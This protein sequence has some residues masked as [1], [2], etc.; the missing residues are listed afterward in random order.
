MYTVKIILKSVSKV[1]NLGNLVIEVTFKSEGKRERVY[2][3]TNEKVFSHHFLKSKI[4]KSNP[5][6][7]Q[8]W[9]RVEEVHGEVKKVL[10]EIEEQYGFC[11]SGLFKDRFF[12]KDEFQEKDF[13]CLYGEFIE[14][15]RITLKPKLV[16]KLKAIENHLNDFFGTRKI[17]PQD[18]N[19]EIINKLVQY[20][21]D[22]VGL[23]PNTIAKNFKFLRQFLNHLYNE[24]I[25]KSS[26][27][28]R[29]QYPREVETHSVV[30]S[31]EEVRKI[32]EYIPESGKFSKVKDLFL[33]LIFTGL[34]FSDAVRINQSWKKGEF[35]VVNTQKTGERVEIPIHGLLRE[36]LEK[37]EYDFSPIVIS[38]QKFNDYVKMLCE[39]AE[40][41]EMVEVVRYMK[42]VKKYEVVPKWKLISSHT[43][44]RTFITISILAGIPLPIIQEITG[45]KK[46]T[47]IQNYIKILN[48]DKLSE[49]HK[50]HTFF[51]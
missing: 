7:K 9:D 25:L 15:K 29:L 37:Y 11:N 10:Y 19:Q 30:L 51:K 21:R 2:V 34:R 13:M 17:Y 24:E 46:L 27:Y 26:K 1:T 32:I 23:Q 6:Y 50:I 22:Q 43:G 38:N 35:L 31:K 8:I 33:V 20:W 42:G 36:I 18:F 28:Q 48:G 49:I 47:T 41:T 39:K 4:S 5:N 45:H 14:L 12:K 44:R 40:I 3:S 16:N